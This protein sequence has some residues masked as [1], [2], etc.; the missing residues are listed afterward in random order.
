MPLEAHGWTTTEILVI[1]FFLVLVIGIGTD[2]TVDVIGTARNR[3]YVR[4]HGQGGPHVS[5]ARIDRE[6]ALAVESMA[7]RSRSLGESTANPVEAG[8]TD[9]ARLRGRVLGN[10]DHVR[11]GT[12]LDE[13]SSDY[14]GTR[15]VAFRSPRVP[16]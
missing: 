6:A 11:Q 12:A 3:R 15:L 7:T 9:R 16:R 13:R 8:G 14:L 5:T 1:F 4:R 10:G 2:K